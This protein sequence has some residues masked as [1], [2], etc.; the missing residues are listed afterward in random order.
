MLG[1]AGGAGSASGR[2]RLELVSRLAS[3]KPT[4]AGSF[5]LRLVF[6]SGHRLKGGER[7]AIDH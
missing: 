6:V 7:G 1:A 2:E 3:P 5:L 4:L